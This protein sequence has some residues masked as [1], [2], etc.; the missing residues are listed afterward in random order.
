LAGLTKKGHAFEL[1]ERVRV[2]QVGPNKTGALPP[3]RP[4]SFCAGIMEGVSAHR[5]SSPR[6]E[7]NMS[8]AANDTLRPTPRQN[9]RWLSPSTPTAACTCLR[10]VLAGTSQLQ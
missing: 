1:P 6:P 10:S 4:T 8:A 9:L 5:I 7:I 2:R 3:A